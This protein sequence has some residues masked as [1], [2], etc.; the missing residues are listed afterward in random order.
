MIWR[1]AISRKIIYFLK[2][3]YIIVMIILS[4]TPQRQSLSDKIPAIRLNENVREDP[5]A[6]PNT[7]TLGNSIDTK[8]EGNLNIW[9]QRKSFFVL[10]RLTFCVFAL[11]SHTLSAYAGFWLLFRGSHPIEQT[12]NLHTFTCNWNIMFG[13]LPYPHRLKV[14]CL[15]YVWPLKTLC[16]V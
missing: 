1:A 11:G 12:F 8:G 4:S 9:Q 16:S 3:L 10:C 5:Y 7:N 13:R 14:S 2:W 15:L 6:N